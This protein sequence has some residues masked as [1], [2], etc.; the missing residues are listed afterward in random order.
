MIDKQ[1]KNFKCKKFLS[2]VVKVNTYTSPLAVEIPSNN[3]SIAIHLIGN[4]PP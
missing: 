1:E 3:A 2:Y 4:L